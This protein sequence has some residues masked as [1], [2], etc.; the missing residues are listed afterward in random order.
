MMLFDFDVL[1]LN[2]EVDVLELLYGDASSRLVQ[3]E[4]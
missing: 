2:T 3:R 4:L 1:V